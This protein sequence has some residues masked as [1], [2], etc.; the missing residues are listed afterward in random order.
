[1]HGNVRS[2]PAEADEAAVNHLELRNGTQN[3]VF[4]NPRSAG[5][6]VFVRN[7]KK[8]VLIAEDFFAEIEW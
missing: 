3:G 7:F 2:I 8:R 6:T 4:L 1:M 5:G